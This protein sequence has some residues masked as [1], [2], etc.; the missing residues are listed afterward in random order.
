MLTHTPIAFRQLQPFAICG[1]IGVGE[2]GAWILQNM[3]SVIPDPKCLYNGAFFL[4]EYKK[5][6]LKNYFHVFFKKIVHLHIHKSYSLI[7][8][9]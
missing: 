5:I 8:A 3:N 7:I 1:K 6:P 4:Q 9:Q 2:V